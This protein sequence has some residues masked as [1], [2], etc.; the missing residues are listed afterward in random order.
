VLEVE[1]KKFVIAAIVAVI[2]IIGVPVFA[3]EA[4]ENGEKSNGKNKDRPESELYYKNI[5][6]EKIYPSGGGYAVRYRK[7]FSL[8]T[9][10]I[11]FEWFGSGGKAE[12]INLPRGRSWP[13]MSVYY[14]E[15]EFSHVRLYVHPQASHQTWGVVPPNAKIDGNFEGVET[16]KIEY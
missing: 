13:S 7:G 1:V 10:Y 3:Q 2:F 4:Q 9:V 5:T 16:I 12:I 14:K 8:A 15:G 11:P 6:L